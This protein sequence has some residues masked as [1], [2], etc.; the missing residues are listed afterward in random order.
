MDYVDKNATQSEFSLR[1]FYYIFFRHMKKILVFFVIASLLSLFYV[2]RIPDLYVSTASILVTAGRENIEMI[3]T[4]QDAV[5]VSRSNNINTEVELL[6]N[7]DNFIE[8][9]DSLGI[10]TFYIP[11][12]DKPYPTNEELSIIRSNIANALRNNIQIQ[13]K[14]GTNIIDVSFGSR[15][16]EMAQNIVSTLIDIYQDRR[17]KI[18][19]SGSQYTFYLE[20]YNATRES[21]DELE[22]K[23]NTLKT[24]MIAGESSEDLSNITGRIDALQQQRDSNSAA[25]AECQSQI[26]YLRQ[27]LRNNTPQQGATNEVPN[28]D[29]QA[30]INNLQIR[31][32]ELLTKY[33]EDNAQ[34]KEI[35]RQIDELRKLQIPDNPETYN[36]SIM[37]QELQT[38]LAE[39]RRLLVSLQ[40]KDRALADRLNIL[41]RAVSEYNEKSSQLSKLERERENLRATYNSYS[42][43]L[44]EANIDQIVQQ[45]KI[46][47]VKIIQPATLPTLPVSSR[48]YRNLFLGLFV[49]FF[50]GI[51]IAF[52][53]E[54]LDHSIKRQDEVSKWLD[55][56]PLASIPYKKDISTI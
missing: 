51:G 33:T 39:Q 44:Q 16:P 19:Y 31:K 38:Q 26:T 21:L 27:E 22:D 8:V 20:Q 13:I 5:S 28:I 11:E 15:S 29:I 24:N 32:Q 9:V 47:N 46:S 43:S 49:G 52:A 42:N 55:L 18:H 37:Y 30:E 23:I 54:F 41:K 35:N 12:E 17:R 40:A 45:Q 6:R 56:R 1:D 25:I 3:P 2:M 4:T 36:S 10:D 50:G 53:S 7:S 14:R 34:I 48:K